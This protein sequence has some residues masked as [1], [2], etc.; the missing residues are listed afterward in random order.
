MVESPE[1]LPPKS[2]NLRWRLLISAI[3]I[4][5][6]GGLFYL[7]H[8]IGRSAPILLLVCLFLAV[9]GSYEMSGLLKTRSFQPRFGLVAAGT[10]AI[11]LATWL[12]P[13]GIGE[14]H[15]VDLSYLG[16]TMLAFSLVVMGLFM[17]SALRF[18]EPGKTMESL[19][20]EI[21]IVVYV[22]V[23]LSMTA[24]LR[25]VAG[26][27]AGYL[28][29]GSLIVATKGGDV[30]AYTLGKLLGRKKL[31]PFLSPGKTWWGARGALLASALFSWLWLTY[32]PP[33]FDPSWEPVPW[34]LAI[35]Y[36][37]AVGIVGMLGDLCESLIKRDVGKKDSAALMPGFGGILD[38]LDSVLYTGPAAYLFWSLFPMASWR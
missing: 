3:L 10:I 12:K 32:M 35:L 36:G 34:P 29:L 13:L 21:L 4:S 20:A 5:T 2:R 26:P 30:G 31:N 17:V 18:R 8:S 38:I 22:G 19:S 28:V 7:D 16:P 9:R 6:L 23:F 14:T 15:M 37:I 33:V 1:Q 27:D 24:Q 11:I 25:W